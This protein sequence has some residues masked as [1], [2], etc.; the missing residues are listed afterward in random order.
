[1][2]PEAVIDIGPGSNPLGFDV[3]RAAIFDVSRAKSDL[4]FEARFNLQ[5]GVRD[6]I[7]RLRGAQ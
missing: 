4:G 3:N 2:I 7:A 6:Y 1:V 5:D